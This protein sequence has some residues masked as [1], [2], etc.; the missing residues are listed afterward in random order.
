[1][2]TKTKKSELRGRLF[3][4]L[5]GIV[6]APTAFELF[7]K[8]VLT[9]LANQTSA[10]LEIISQQFNANEGYLN[11]ALRVLSSQG[12]LKMDITEDNK[13]HYS[14]NKKGQFAL[15]YIPFYKDCVELIR[16]SEKF[17]SRKFE[18]EPFLKQ[19]KIHVKLKKGY[20]S[21]P[22]DNPIEEEVRN[23]ILTHIE[24]IILAPSIV[25]LGMSGMFHSYFMQSS[26]RPEEFHKDPENFGRLLDI[27]TDYDWFVKEKGTYQFTDT[28]LFYARR[29]TAYGVTVSYIPNLRKLDEL[30]FGNPLVLKAAPGEKEKHVDRAMNVWGSGGAH[31]TYFKV[32]DQALIELFNRPMEEQPKGVLDMGCGNGAFLRHIFNLIE[33]QTERGKV[34]EEY[35]LMLVGADYNDAAIQISK[36][37][38][39]EADIWAKVIHGD[40]SNPDQLANDLESLYGI[41]LED[42]L[43]VRS[44]L[45]HNRIWNPPVQQDHLPP[46]RSSGAYAFEGKRIPNALVEQSLREH[47]ESW[48]PY[49][50]KHGLL[51]IELHTVD[52]A[53]VADNL[54]KTAATA[55]DA[56]HGFSDQYILEID[57]Y[58]K[59][60]EESGL[61]IN[62]KFSRRFP[63]TDYATI[64]VNLIEE[65]R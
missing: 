31:S 25:A 19:E 26:F 48:K 36:R 62:P 1:M 32:V 28:G 7:D 8:G 53:I 46:A 54:G 13:V 6:C 58:E 50:R 24:G 23:Q 64:S 9:W 12:W 30:I 43:N 18:V 61:Q 60:I 41:Q 42:L 39:I 27:F 34:L 59:L 47:L 5:D 29:A 57:L 20:G 55:Y 65:S 52:P 56:T 2:L 38:L 3:R 4:Q 17:H 16:F 15:Q 37:N 33:Q 45:D 44:F 10:P 63:N 21:T 49:I 51:I 35:P 40:I 11:V 14:M 22:S